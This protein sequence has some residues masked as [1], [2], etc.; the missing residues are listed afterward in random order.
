MEHLEPKVTLGKRCRRE[1][2]LVILTHKF[3]ELIKSGPNQTIDLNLAVQKLHVQKRRIYDI[4]NV[5]EGIGIV[6]KSGKNHIRWV[7]EV[8]HCKSAKFNKNVAD[9]ELRRQFEISEKHLE[10]INQKAARLDELIAKMKEQQVAT[11]EEEEHYR[12]FAYINPADLQSVLRDNPQIAHMMCLQTPKA[13][14]LKMFTT[15]TATN[16][17]N[18]DQDD[19]FAEQLRPGHMYKLTV[20]TENADPQDPG[21]KFFTIERRLTLS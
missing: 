5:L 14:V 12:E 7:G 19:Y 18:T 6:R 1:N 15:Q 4:T 3:L 20:N 17:E 11:I 21:L 8:K 16:T 9:P 13:S 10:A 2:G